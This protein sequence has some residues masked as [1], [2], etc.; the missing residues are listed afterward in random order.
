MLVNLNPN[1]TLMVCLHLGVGSYTLYPF[2]LFPCQDPDFY[3]STTSKD[4]KTNPSGYENTPPG[5]HTHTHSYTELQ[6]LAGWVLCLSRVSHV[7]SYGS[8]CSCL[9]QFFNPLGFSSLSFGLLTSIHKQILLKDTRGVRED[10]IFLLN[11]PVAW[12]SKMQN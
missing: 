12:R 4:I 6:V 11:Q 10:N 7:P 2:P 3:Y 9:P 8:A 1:M 5:T